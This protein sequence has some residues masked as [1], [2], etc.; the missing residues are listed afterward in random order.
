[1][2]FVDEVRVDDTEVA[3]SLRIR[4]SCDG[5][6][7]FSSDERELFRFGIEIKSES[8]S[9]WKKRRE[10]DPKHVQQ[11]MLY[12]ACLDLPAMYFLYVDKESGEPTPFDSSF[13]LPFDEEVWGRQVE[14]RIQP[15]LQANSPLDLDPET[16]FHCDFCPY[17]KICDPQAKP[18]PTLRIPGKR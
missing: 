10:P 5:I 1:M 8:S 15:V 6:F 7:T 16:G 14:T 9:T 3:K 17:K 18:L 2:S 4:S 12:M 11:A 13:V